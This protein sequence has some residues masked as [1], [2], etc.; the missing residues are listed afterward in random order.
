M[1]KKHIPI[2]IVVTLLLLHT[3]NLFSPLRLV[4]DAVRY[5]NILEFLQHKLPDSSN[6]A[7][8]YFP[9]GY[10][11]YLL[12]LNKTIGLH[13]FLIIISNYVF[14]ISAIFLYTKY[15]RRSA[16]KLLIIILFSLSW[17][18][19][20]FSVYPLA[21]SLFTLLFIG[22]SIL[23]NEKQNLFRIISFVLLLA[24]SMWI[25]SAGVSIVIGLVLYFIYLHLIYVSRYKNRNL[26][27]S[28]YGLIVAIT[29]FF[30]LY[31]WSGLEARIE[32]IREL[33]LHNITADLFSR[34]ATHFK[35]M[36][37]IIFNFPMAR[38]ISLL[39]IPPTAEKIIEI[40]TGLFFIY[41]IVRYFK[42]SKTLRKSDFIFIGYVLMILIWPFYDARFFLPVIIYF[43][44]VIIFTFENSALNRK[45]V[46]QFSYL[47]L[48]SIMGVFALVYSIRITISHNFLLN[49]YGN[50]PALRNQ[51]K[52][53]F[54]SRSNTSNSFDSTYT[55]GKSADTSEN[56]PYYLLKTYN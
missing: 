25:R 22:T 49:N 38:I 23:A 21:E 41:L 20:K 40:L 29:C 48:Y 27:Y 4:T 43:I 37:E 51:Y 2:I 3:I 16:N 6:A 35:E 53:F 26:I 17:V 56:R 54:L 11:N 1:S 18:V 7:H 36:S 12:I 24:L 19:T 44:D 31:N 46:L 52:L 47:A 5:L 55:A 42:A 34:F 8:D 45:I 33:K 30:I 39:H 28:G 13:S 14:L 50:S 32:Y 10:P 9:K 15:L